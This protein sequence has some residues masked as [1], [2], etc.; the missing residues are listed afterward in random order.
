MQRWSPRTTRLRLA[1]YEIYRF[2][3]WELSGPRGQQVLEG[4]FTELLARQGN[5]TL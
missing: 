1:G 5:P 4:F 3:G 2:G